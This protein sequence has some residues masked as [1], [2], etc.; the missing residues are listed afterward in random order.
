MR[1]GAVVRSYIFVWNHALASGCVVNLSFVNRCLDRI[2]RIDDGRSRRG[3]GWRK[4]ELKRI[5]ALGGLGSGLKQTGIV[6]RGEALNQLGFCFRRHVLLLQ[7][8]HQ[9]RI[10]R[11]NDG[12][13]DGRVDLDDRRTE[14]PLTRSNLD[15][16]I[17]GGQF[18]FRRGR[19]GH[20]GHARSL[21]MGKSAQD[22][23]G[24]SGRRYAE[25]V[26]DEGRNSGG[27]FLRF[28]ILLVLLE[29]LTARA[30]DALDKTPHA[31][32]LPDWRP[33]VIDLGVRMVGVRAQPRGIG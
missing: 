24:G 29:K 30:P 11:L 13:R 25:G 21:R 12:G 32:A 23:G 28:A 16:Q 4:W 6:Q 22:V 15:F 5:G 8:A 18:R 1:R 27:R 20:A 3:W 2:E 10:Q 7:L 14:R 19:A 9:G 33:V 31:L 26:G 17:T